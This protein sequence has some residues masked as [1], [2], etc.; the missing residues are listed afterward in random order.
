MDCDR[1]DNHG[2]I[3]SSSIA[4]THSIFDRFKILYL[5][6]APDVEQRRS[7]TSSGKGKATAA[8]RILKDCR[9]GNLGQS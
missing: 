9:C 1:G 8:L 7:N 3:Q 4:A 5:M 6:V 2:L